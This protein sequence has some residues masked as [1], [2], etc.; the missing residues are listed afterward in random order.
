VWVDK[1]Q[2]RRGELPPSSRRDVWLAA[3]QAGAAAGRATLP[4]AGGL[5][6]PTAAAAAASAYYYRAALHEVFGASTPAPARLFRIPFLG[7]EPS[8][9]PEE[10]RA[11][12]RGAARPRSPANHS[13]Q[14]QRPPAGLPR[15]R[16]RPRCSCSRPLRRARRTTG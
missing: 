3:A 11:A 2:L 8:V 15:T 10:V 6:A 4:S 7:V 1:A 16:R 12:A 5:P 13:A 9:L 14:P